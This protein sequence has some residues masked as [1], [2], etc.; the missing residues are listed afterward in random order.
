MCTWVLT[1]Y[2][3][4]HHHHADTLFSLGHSS[5]LGAPRPLLCILSPAQLAKLKEARDAHVAAAQEQIAVRREQSK[6]FLSEVQ[7]TA[8]EQLA[9][10]RGKALV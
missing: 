2:R 10:A 8:S 7:R 1:H 3:H 6:R 4:H 9:S 5:A